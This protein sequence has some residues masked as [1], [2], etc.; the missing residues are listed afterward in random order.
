MA[1]EFLLVLE[2]FLLM[3]EGDL[4]YKARL[5]LASTF[6]DFQVWDSR[7]KPIFLIQE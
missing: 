5:R 2:I 6:S 1:S 3:A 7:G 4:K